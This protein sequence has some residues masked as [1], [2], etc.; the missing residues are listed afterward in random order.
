MAARQTSD[1]ERG[2]H[3]TETQ[4]TIFG[5]HLLISVSRVLIPNLH[6]KVCTVSQIFSLLFCF[7]YNKCIYFIILYE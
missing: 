4:G 2:R 6:C 3:F 1:S 7:V 5:A